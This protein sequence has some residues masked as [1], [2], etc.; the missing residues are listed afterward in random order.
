MNKD[1]HHFSVSEVFADGRVLVFVYTRIGN[2]INA[3]M[4][5]Y[6]DET[7]RSGKRTLDIHLYSHDGTI[8]ITV[9]DE[10]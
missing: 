7:M 6:D 9:N 3:V 10:G 4:D 5:V 2:S 1:V 8:P